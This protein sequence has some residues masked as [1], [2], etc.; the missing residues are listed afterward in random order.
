MA[1]ELPDLI[2][3][4]ELMQFD[5]I[6]LKN[7]QYVGASTL[8]IH[9]NETLDT[10][11]FN[12]SVPSFWV[13]GGF[14]DFA[15]DNQ[16]FPFAELECD[17]WINDVKVDPGEGEHSGSD[18]PGFKYYKAR[19]PD[20]NVVSFVFSILNFSGSTKNFKLKFRVQST[21]T[22]EVLPLVIASSRNF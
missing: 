3:E 8:L 22:G 4:V 10:Y 13:A 1:R 14:V 11:D 17:I 12:D 2:K 20:D 19:R 16:D 21:D 6:E 9:T 7:K 15:A 5:L 18:T